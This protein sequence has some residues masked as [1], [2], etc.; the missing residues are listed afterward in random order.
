MFNL[1]HATLL[2]NSNQVIRCSQQI[3]LLNPF[4]RFSSCTDLRTYILPLR[5]NNTRALRTHQ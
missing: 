3:I 1:G 4:G 2:T 5:P